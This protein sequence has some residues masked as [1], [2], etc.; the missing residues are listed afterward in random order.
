MESKIIDL[1]YFSGTGNTL[2]ACQTFEEE[3]KNYGFSVNLIRMEKADPSKINKDNILGLA[4]P[5]AMCFSYPI[6]FDFIRALP[7]VKG[8]KA[9]ML[10][11][12][13]GNAFGLAG[14][15]KNILEEKGFVPAAAFT[16]IMPSNIFVVEDEE[17]NKIIRAKGLRDIRD[18]ASA[19]AMGDGVWQ[20][21]GLKEELSYLLYLT[22]SSSWKVK[23]FQKPFK[24]KLI[25]DK[26]TKCGR[27][28]KLCPTANISMR[29]GLPQFGEK[30]QYCMRCVS[31][32]PTGAIKSKF[33]FK[34]GAYKAA[35]L[36]FQRKS[37]GIKI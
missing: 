26:C 31:Y 34:G 17:K 18:F 12:M 30:C 6:I 23:L 13:G 29:D 35:P 9:I 3:V 28:A 1:Y 4:F 36:P 14:K 27:C 20:G 32:C 24:N 8:T 37:N 11:T 21:G 7:A 33:I 10:A 2:L 15:L 19:F 25:A 16:A 22:L 5:V